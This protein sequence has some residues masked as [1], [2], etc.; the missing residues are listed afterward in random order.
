MSELTS[1]YTS[2]IYKSKSLVDARE[3]FARFQ[4][5]VQAIVNFIKDGQSWRSRRNKRLSLRPKLNIPVFPRYSIDNVT[6][7]P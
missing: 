3:N 2:A 6:D 5:T 1:A 7:V 4:T